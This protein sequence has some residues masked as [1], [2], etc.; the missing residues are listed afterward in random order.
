M[1]T[2]FSER[3]QSS[4]VERSDLPAITEEILPDL[5]DIHHRR[6]INLYDTLVVAFEV[7]LQMNVEFE[8]DAVLQKWSLM[9]LQYSLQRSSCSSEPIATVI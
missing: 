6:R 7:V 8:F 5:G 2:N 4:A 9:Y 3:G 1:V